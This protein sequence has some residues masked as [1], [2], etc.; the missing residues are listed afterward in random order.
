MVRNSR[1]EWIDCRDQ[2]EMLL[3]QVSVSALSLKTPL[4]TGHV[5]TG[6]LKTNTFL[7]VNGITRCYKTHKEL[8]RLCI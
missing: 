3:R 8:R 2:D 5:D 7:V 4:T 1:E 6:Y